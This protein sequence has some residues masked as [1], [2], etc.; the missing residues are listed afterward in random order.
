MDIVFVMSCRGKRVVESAPGD[1]SCALEVQ[2]DSGHLQ[3][4]VQD[5][6]L[7]LESF[8]VDFRC[9]AG[10]FATTGS[11]LKLS[12]VLLDGR[13]FLHSGCPLDRRFWHWRYFLRLFDLPNLEKA[14]IDYAA[15]PHGKLPLP[16]ESPVLRFLTSL[17]LTRSALVLLSNNRSRS[18]ES[19]SL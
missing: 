11:F 13:S 10:V 15:M 9:L 16:V 5:Q 7:S 1:L 14:S 17:W 8:F 12:Q 18:A 3:E 19:S 4:S 2:E 6:H